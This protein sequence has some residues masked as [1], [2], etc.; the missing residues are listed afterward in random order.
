MAFWAIVSGLAG[1][2]LSSHLWTTPWNGRN[3]NAR[4]LDLEV[5]APRSL[6]SGASVG[7]QLRGCSWGEWVS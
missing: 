2:D 1:Q 5:E 4:S 6:V 3:T 7:A